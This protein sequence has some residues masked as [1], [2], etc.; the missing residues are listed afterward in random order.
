L[1]LQVGE[2]MYDVLK[3]R[4]LVDISS[5]LKAAWINLFLIGT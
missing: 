3:Y 1:L 2:K 5:L 4:G